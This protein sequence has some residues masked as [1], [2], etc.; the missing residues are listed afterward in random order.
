MPCR[1]KGRKKETVKLLLQK[2]P[3]PGLILVSTGAVI[4]REVGGGMG[5]GVQREA[6]PR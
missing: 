5:G 6:R 4:L 2:G 1:V 3:A